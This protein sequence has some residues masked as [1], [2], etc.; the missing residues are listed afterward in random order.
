LYSFGNRTG[1]YLGVIALLYGLLAISLAIK[2][3]TRTL[4]VSILLTTIGIP[5]VTAIAIF[6]TCSVALSL[7][8]W[9]T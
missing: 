1:N 9:T 6:G 2:P 5:V 7:H 8:K 3:N 4:L